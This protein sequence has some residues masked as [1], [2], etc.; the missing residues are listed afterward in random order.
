MSPRRWCL[1]PCIHISCAWCLRTLSSMADVV[2]REELPIDVEE[3]DLFALRLNQSALTG[4]ELICLCYS[5]KVSHGFSSSHLCRFQEP[6]GAAPWS[7]TCASKHLGGIG[8]SRDAV[9]ARLDFGE[10]EL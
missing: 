6:S 9:Y 3:G 7:W 2:D 4:L 10:G 5:H 1:C 8:R